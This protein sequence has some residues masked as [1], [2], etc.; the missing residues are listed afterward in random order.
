[1]KQNTLER[2]LLKVLKQP[3]PKAKLIKG[4]QATLPAVL[5]CNDDLKHPV[6]SYGLRLDTDV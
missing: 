2:Q 1:M 3:H 4:F 5:G 6:G